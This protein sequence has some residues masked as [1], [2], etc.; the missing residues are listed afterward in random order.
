MMYIDNG[1]C[2][3]PIQQGFSKR[4]SIALYADKRNE[5]TE[6]LK[7]GGKKKIQ[8]PN[9]IPYIQIT[10]KEARRL[11]REGLATAVDHNDVYELR[12]K[13]IRRGIKN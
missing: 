1:I 3:V 4:F 9:I 6:Y 10:L 7:D 11:L 12:S 8:C 2:T 13:Y 5:L